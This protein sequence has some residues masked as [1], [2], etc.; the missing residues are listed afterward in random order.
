[1]RTLVKVP[2]GHPSRALGCPKALHFVV[3]QP[4]NDSG[5]IADF[6]AVSIPEASHQLAASM[7]Q[8]RHYNAR[9][10]LI[11]DT[12]AQAKAAARTVAELLPSHRR[13]SL[14]RAQAG[15]FGLQ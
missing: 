14:E 2:A 8:A 12:R 3:F 7:A 13:V 5:G 6:V 11:C 1:M 4:T 9:V 10:L 15:G